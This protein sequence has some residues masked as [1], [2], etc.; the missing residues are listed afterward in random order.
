MKPTFER[1]LTSITIDSLLLIACCVPLLLRFAGPFDHVSAALWIS[2]AALLLLIFGV[3]SVTGMTPGKAFTGMC[4]RRDDGHP[5]AIQALA[6][7]TAMKAVPF[8]LFIFGLIASSPLADIFWWSAVILIQIYAT[9]YYF[10]MARRDRSAF[11][12][13]VKTVILRRATSL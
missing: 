1:R 6:T 3:E 9:L 11:D 10:A 4:V 13:P 8:A 12:I 5:A 2:A 7:R